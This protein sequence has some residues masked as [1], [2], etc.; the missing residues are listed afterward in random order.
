[1]KKL[2][3]FRPVLYSLILLTGLTVVAREEKVLQIFKG[4]EI[5]HELPISEIDYIEI[6]DI[7]SAPADMGATVNGNRITINWEAVEG[8]T[9]QLFRS[10]DNIDFSL[11]A[12]GIE[13]NFFVDSAPLPGTNYYKVKAIIDGKESDYSFTVA[14][15]VGDASLPS[16]F[17]LG[18][19]GFNNFL[20]PY[21]IQCLTE[22]SAEGF[23]SFVDNLSTINGTNL[24]YAVDNA[25]NSL[26]AETFPADLY[27]VAIVTF[28]DG[29]DRGSLDWNE[30]YMSSTE[31]LEA[32]NKRLNEETVSGIGISSYTVGVEGNDVVNNDN[33][34]LFEKNLQTLATSPSNVFKV[35]DMAKVNDTF[36]QIANFLGETKYVQKFIF[37]IKSPSD[38]ELCRF[39]FD[40][41]SSPL[42]SKLYIEGTFDRRTKTLRDIR[43]VGLTSTSGS[44]LQ[45]LTNEARYD[46]F[47]F[48]G[49]QALNGEKL[50]TDVKYYYTE[51]NIWQFDS[52]F[53][54]DPGK[55]SLEKVKRSAAIML[56]LDC[57]NSLQGDDF[58]RL[59]QSAK[60]FIEILVENSAD[61]G[62]V[63]S[64]TLD[65]EEM[66]LGT[67]ES[68][69]LHATV[70]P[71]TAMLKDVTWTSLYPEVASV[72]DYGKVT[73]HAPGNTTIICKTVDGGYTATCNVKVITRVSNITL[74]A[75]QTELNIG[76]NITL[77]ATITPSDASIREL[78]WSSSDESIATVNGGLITALKAGTAVITARATDGSGVS[79][80]CNVTVRQ[81]VTGIAFNASSYT[82]EKGNFIHPGVNVLPAN[83]SNKNF[84]IV[85]A[86][87]KI[88][89][90]FI[91][92]GLIYI[93]GISFGTTTVTATSDE[94]GFTAQCEVT[95][96]PS[97]TPSHLALA[98][99]KDNIF[100]YIPNSEYTSV[101]SGY[102]KD[103]VV[104]YN[105]GAPF[106][107]KLTSPT[108]TAY[109][110]TK[111]N[112]Y[113]TLPTSTQAQQIANDWTAINAALTKYGGTSLGTKS[114]WTS[115]P[116]GT[117]EYGYYYN[118]S[119]VSLAGNSSATYYI[120]GI[121]NL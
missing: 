94:G 15:T 101:P 106:V 27:D 38:A 93:T 18:I 48:E 87:P 29:L 112:T 28:T 110:F 117:G 40:K 74:S 4:G 115:T 49:L 78:S 31:Y 12:S 91:N 55:V 76:E 121:S 113:A 24:Y 39:V 114:Y 111:A 107:L 99:K 103:G 57:S 44:E 45:G 21:P 77:D 108:S 42:D 73:A 52:E 81:P 33:K 65:R 16:G 22:G 14:A 119:G 25:I 72:D 53:E 35:T 3:I 104:V 47:T 79:A 69:T 92:G 71:A 41:V 43:Y 70:Y 20:Y 51:Q 46:V 105:G 30:N 98:L 100:Y 68:F 83:A 64:V 56:N 86:D 11:L 80:K 97:L 116:R 120:R 90:A 23:Y 96:T 8:A 60:N 9:Y 88:A 36:I 67:G 54:M 109:N 6:N 13:E 102:T 5:I 85:S 7:I 50:P 19:I 37:E 63:A 2:S 62:E 26:E 34:I 95:V 17:Y 66:T 1:M 58:A 10:A 89:T 32:L 84:S 61:K 118:S 59:K 75:S 82:V